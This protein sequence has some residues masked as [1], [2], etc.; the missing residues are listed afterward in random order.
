MK[1]VAFILKGYPRVSETFIAQEI[2][3]LEQRGFQ[4]EILSLR[5]AREPER[6]PIVGRIRAPVTYLPEYIWPQIGSVLW[7]NSKCLAKHPCGYLRA[8][9]A[10]VRQ[11]LRQRTVRPARRF[12]QAGWAAGR[13]RI[14]APGGVGH[15]HAH[16]AHTP[17]EVAFH[18]SL[19]TG[20]PYSISAH[21]KDIYTITPRELVERINSAAL[22]MTCTEFNWR[23]LRALPGIQAE[24]I[25][26]VYHGIDLRTFKR[27]RPLP[28]GPLFAAGLRGFVSVGRL[29]EKKGFDVVL[30]AL[31]VLKSR[32]EQFTYDIYGA[33][34]LEQPL[35]DLVK[36]LNLQ[37]EVRFHRTATHPQIIQRLNEGGIYLGGF[38]ITADGDRDGIPNTVAEA[39]AMEM[40]VLV[41]NVSG[42]PELVEHGLSGH[43]VPPN[44][45]N[46]LV[47]ALAQMLANPAYCRALAVRARVRVQEVFNCDGCIEAC[48]RL[49][50][51]L[52]SGKK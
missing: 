25:H 46:A 40:P 12:F 26:R 5:Q 15:L 14:G 47:T 49:L 11:V 16:F 44:D 10:T 38:K 37:A 36:Q 4:I 20:L 51:P 1:K 34:E 19:I 39:M 13:C 8:F 35:A 24:K 22:L 52:V 23:F 42:V 27:S 21:A 41:S 6:Q 29:V 45:V 7:E 48:A 18:L 43:L 50:Q 17:T 30:R 28:E 31:A 3:Q 2:Y 32:G 9:A 33:G